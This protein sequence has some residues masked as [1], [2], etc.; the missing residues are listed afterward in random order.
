MAISYTSLT[1]YINGLYADGTLSDADYNQII[2]YILAN[3]NLENSPRDLIQM[4]RGNYA[5]LPNLAQGEPGF[6]LDT[7]ELYVGGQNGN[8]RVSGN[9]AS[10]YL[11][12]GDSYDTL[13]APG[14]VSK[15]AT[16]LGLSSSDYWN[17]SMSGS[18]IASG[19]WK[20]NIEAWVNSHT[21]EVKN[22]GCVLLAGGINDSDSTN[23]PL[24][25]NAMTALGAYC[26]SALP[27]AKV[28]IAF[29]G[30]A[31]DTSSILA[32]RTANYRMAVH[33]IYR[34][35]ARYG[36][37][38]LP[39]CEMVLHN[40]NYLL[41]DGLHPNTD[42]LEVISDALAG[43]IKVGSASVTYFY[44]AVFTP[45]SGTKNG[46]ISQSISNGQV[47]TYFTDFN[48]NGTSLAF[49][50]GKYTKIGD[51]KL[52]LGNRIVPFATRMMFEVGGRNVTYDVVMK[53]ENDGLY[54]KIN[55]IDT[56][57]WISATATVVQAYNMSVC[58]VGIRD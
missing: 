21:N 57:G 42:G 43:A 37:E 44:D 30:W 46:Q 8:V 29:I 31:L 2:L 23:F 26:K 51:L 50:G 24:L 5:N 28:K 13:T 39:G 32:G 52:T 3:G 55:Q 41:S 10:K 15:T 48:I 7:E 56:G 35:A 17:L 9:K 34:W 58:N 49:S 38:Y 1:A 22:I 36:M 20:S 47:V 4:R 18:N 12:V 25:A 40:R 33:E 27:N 19:L 16:K 53:C 11:F 54:V 45:V 6:C 14:W